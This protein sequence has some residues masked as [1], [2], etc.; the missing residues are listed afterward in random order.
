M[1]RDRRVLLVEDD[2]ATAELFLEQLRGD[3]VPIEH[4]ATARAADQ[5]VR[6]RRPVL[7]LVDLSLPDMAGRSLA[8][9][10]ASDPLLGEIPIWIV[11]NSDAQDNL[12]WHEVPNVQRYFL[13]SRVSLGRLSV[14]IR[15]TLG[16]PYG[17]R[18]VNRLAR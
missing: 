14:E 10:W 17:D 4:A 16:L 9:S 5:F 15:A 2:P 7:V 18:L 1:A 11:S 3:G 13:K 6:S 8:E 12:W